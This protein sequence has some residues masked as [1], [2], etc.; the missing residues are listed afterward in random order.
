MSLDKKQS[1]RRSSSILCWDTGR[2]IKLN[3]LFYDDVTLDAGWTVT[4]PPQSAR[5]RTVLAR[6][7][8]VGRSQRSECDECELPRAAA[9]A[10]PVIRTTERGQYV[11]L[12]RSSKQHNS[13]RKPLL[14]VQ[15]LWT[16]L[17]SVYPLTCRII[18]AVDKGIFI[19]RKEIWRLT[20]LPRISILILIHTSK[21]LAIP[22]PH[23][24]VA[25]DK[26]PC[27]I[28]CDISLLLGDNPAELR[29]Y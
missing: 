3:Q 22:D 15:D 13:S 23:D 16:V 24:I 19:T 29:G 2:A 17:S 7:L 11:S 8:R 6:R 10:P 28:V 26:Y 25:Y 12:I 20:I 27:T 9:A 18:Q 1:K 5:Y 21:L 4:A 14:C